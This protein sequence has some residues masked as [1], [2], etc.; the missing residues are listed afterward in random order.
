MTRTVPFP[1][2]A[3]K[4][5]GAVPERVDSQ[6]SLNPLDALSQPLQPDTHVLVHETSLTL[7]ERQTA[8]RKPV[9]GV[10]LRGGLVREAAPPA[11]PGEQREVWVTLHHPPHSGTTAGSRPVSNVALHRSPMSTWPST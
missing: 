11:G 9:A 3:K 7:Q 2:L 8:A 10:A 4:P 1:R 6:T 5:D